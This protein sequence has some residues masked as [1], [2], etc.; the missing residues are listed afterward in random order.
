MKITT[1]RDYCI[2]IS[3]RDHG[4]GI[5]GEDLKNVYEPFF[6]G[7]NAERM[8]GYGFG[9]PLVYKI[10]KMHKGNIEINSRVNYGTEVII[11]LPAGRQSYFQYQTEF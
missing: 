8:K 2:S 6:R 11:T 4:I 3:V 9:L 5:S 7:S 10:I 1:T